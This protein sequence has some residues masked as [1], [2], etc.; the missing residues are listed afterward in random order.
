MTPSHKSE[1]NY[2]YDQGICKHYTCCRTAEPIHIDGM[3][4]KPSWKLAEK[5]PRFVDMVSGK[6]VAFDTRAALLWDDENLYVAFWVQEPDIQASLTERD[7]L[8][9]NDNDVEIFIAGQ[10]CYYEFEINAFGTV[11]EVLYV[12][13]DAYT[14]GSRFDIPELDLLTQK[15]E[16]LGGD[17]DYRTH[18]RKGRWAFREWDMRGMKSAVK[19]N[20]TINK[21]DDIDEGWTVELA[22]PW[23]GMKLLAGDRPLPP[24]E[25]DIW[26]MDLSRFQKFT[27][28]DTVINPG[29]AWNTHNAYDS[30]IPELFTYIHFTDK[31]VEEAH[32]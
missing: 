31:I 25:G 24:R 1:N 23:E 15:V 27:D 26:R 29:W 5:S 14:H 18:P 3:L 12:W 16:V 2:G 9:W 30:H 13:Q 4:D 8:I 32:S 6:A 28:R 7:S 19:I 10:D 20:G 22:F 17:Y 21:S 11:F